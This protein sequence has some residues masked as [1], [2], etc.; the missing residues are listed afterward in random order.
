MFGVSSV[1]A[2]R[3]SKL[4]TSHL[5]G[6]FLNFF[7]LYNTRVTD[8]LPPLSL[9]CKDRRFSPN[10]DGFPQ[11]TEKFI[12]T[13]LYLSVESPVQTVGVSRSAPC[14]S[15]QAEL[16]QGDNGIL[17]SADIERI[18]QTLRNIRATSGARV[19]VLFTSP[20]ET[21]TVF[22]V[23]DIKCRQMFAL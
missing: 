22:Q 19:V 21:K 20:A 11:C 1:S 4:F 17:T 5:H 18:R 16:P 7:Y 9:H 14:V 10:F 23:C 12:I 2:A 8:P 3:V 6:E 15:Q 13:F